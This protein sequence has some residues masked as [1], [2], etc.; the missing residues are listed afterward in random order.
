MN[1]LSKLGL[2][3]VREHEE[4]LDDLVSK[5][6]E[7]MIGQIQII[8]MQVDETLQ[9][10]LSASLVARDIK[11]TEPLVV[12]LEFPFSFV[13]GLSKGSQEVA[14]FVM[15]RLAKIV[16]A[17]LMDALVKGDDQETVGPNSYL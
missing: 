16:G 7:H 1:I 12:R 13:L 8:T 11:S 17:R 3:R 4:K 15:S 9:Q 2:M 10:L 5:A 6:N 14:E